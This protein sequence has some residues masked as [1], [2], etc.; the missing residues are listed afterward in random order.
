MWS[1]LD[2]ASELQLGG[3]W[4][5]WS[6][7]VLLILEIALLVWDLP[8]QSLESMFGVGSL[9]WG[10]HVRSWR[11]SARPRHIELVMIRKSRY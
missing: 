5:C 2:S 7:N 4:L 9:C 11:V 10:H 1:I 6:S 8:I 3:L